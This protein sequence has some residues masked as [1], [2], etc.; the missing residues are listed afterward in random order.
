MKKLSQTVLPGLL[1]FGLAVGPRSASAAAGDLDTTFG[2]RGVT[3]TTLTT[4]NGNNSAIPY[5]VKLQ[6]DGKILVLVNVTSSTTAGESTTT[7]VLRYTAAGA[8]DSTFGS[9]GI[10]VLPTTLGEME[11][12]ALQPNG[13]IVVAGFGVGGIG[14]ERLNANG[15]PDT[16]FGSGGVATA[17]LG[18]RGAGPQIVA[19][20]ETN[21]DIMVVAQLEPA[22][23]RQPFQTLLARFT[24]AGALDPAF[25]TNG[26]TIST[27]PA[28]CTA[29]AELA[30]GE[31][32]VV[33]AQAIA[34]F[35]A[36]GRPESTATGGMIAASAG[37]E[38]P[39][40]P[41]VF[42]PN[43]DYLFATDLF[44]GEESRGQNSSAQVLR[45]NGT[46]SADATFPNPSFHYIGNGGS[47]IEAVANAVAVQANGDIVVAGAQTTFAQTGATTV[48]G[49]ARLTSN[50]TLD[51]TFGNGGTVTNSIPAGTSGYQGVVIQPADGKIIALGTANNLTQLTL[52][53]FL[54]Q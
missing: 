5:S 36:A 12:M 31:I 17:S 7:D 42:Q 22:G 26:T 27:A 46:G 23:R 21:G 4:A 14:V 54:G 37:S 19:L 52:T 49:L 28:G 40:T 45:F 10:A 48:N 50:G 44:V 53:R 41:S 16:A 30:T 51:S 13:Q 38:E 1:V 8:L 35:T 9:N 11:S 20:V 29:L 15:T 2:T 34:H 24:S 33:N 32:Q 43:G 25:G 3:V 18:G 47:G 39:S 6:T